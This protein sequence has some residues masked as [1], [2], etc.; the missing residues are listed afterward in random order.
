MFV[1]TYLHFAVEKVASLPTTFSQITVLG[2]ES[3]LSAVQV[4][5]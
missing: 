4:G 1:E 5:C 2:H 3:N